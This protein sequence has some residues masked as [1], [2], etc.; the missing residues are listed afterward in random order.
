MVFDSPEKTD[1]VNE[2]KDH[3][4][5]LESLTIT[6]YSH[7]RTCS[8]C[9]SYLTNRDSDPDHQLFVFFYEKQMVLK[10]FVDYCIEK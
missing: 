7:A 1:W 6:S 3:E 5:M 10:S 9:R 8:V 2:W 4:T